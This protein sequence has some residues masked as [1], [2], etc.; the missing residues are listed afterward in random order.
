M[1][2]PGLCSLSCVHT[3]VCQYF[4][5][6]CQELQLAV[7]LQVPLETDKTNK[8]DEK[9]RQRG[10][11]GRS[12]RH[13]KTGMRSGQKTVNYGWD[14]GRVPW[15][16]W[17]KV[18]RAAA[19]VLLRTHHCHPSTSCEEGA[20]PGHP[21]RSSR[22]GRPWGLRGVTSEPIHGIEVEAVTWAGR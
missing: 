4:L 6:H 12:R 10:R 3:H 2:L 21:P 1:W 18:Q 20:R 16:L 19:L 11:G 5:P 13:P 9:P 22:E 8:G 7:S 14:P 15:Q 17:G